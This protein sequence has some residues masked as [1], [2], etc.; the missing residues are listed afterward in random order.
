MIG[1]S[2]NAAMEDVEIEEMK[3]KVKEM[4]AEAEK[5]RQMQSQLEE[6]Q[7]EVAAQDD[8][9]SRSVFVNNVRIPLL[10]LGRLFH[11]ARGATGVFP[12]MWNY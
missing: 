7:Q 6:T 10:T 1:F 12:S 2:F 5:L 9:D 3:R 11:H 4:E 8:T